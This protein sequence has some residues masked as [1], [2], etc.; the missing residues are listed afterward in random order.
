MTPSNAY[1]AL[2]SDATSCLPMPAALTRSKQLNAY[3]VHWWPV[4]LTMRILAATARSTSATISS[5][6]F[7]KAST[8]KLGSTPT[9]SNRSRS[10][11]QVQMLWQTSALRRDQDNQ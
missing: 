10:L 1:S 2:A 6:T 9:M 5:E 4:Q 7:G 11:A 8:A 3:A